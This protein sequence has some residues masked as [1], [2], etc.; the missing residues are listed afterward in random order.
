M[1]LCKDGRHKAWFGGQGVGGS[2]IRGLQQR[3]GPRQAGGV[4]D[5]VIELVV[6]I[7]ESYEGL[8]GVPAHVS[9][10]PMP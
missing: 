3:S 2:S 5:I 8:A 4:R 10:S 1:A 7:G 6:A 9:G